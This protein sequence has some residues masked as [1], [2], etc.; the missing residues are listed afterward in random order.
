MAKEGLDVLVIERGEYPGSKNVSGALLHSHILLSIFPNFWDEA[1]VERFVTHRKLTFLTP[2]TSL[3]VDFR[4]DYFAK[5]P[6]NGFTVLR[7]K[8][9][10]WLAKKAEDAGALI[11]T[12]TL[13]EDLIW[14]GD[15][16]IGVKTR[17]QD[18]EVHAHV[19]IIAEGANSILTQ[20]AGLKRDMPPQEMAIGAKEVI[21]L[22]E[23]IINERFNLEG[24]EGAS[25]HYIGECTG[26]VPGGGFLYTNGNSISLG[27]VCRIWDLA[28]QRLKIFDLVE[29]FKSHPHISSLIK[30]GVLKE[31]SGHMIPEGGYK[32]MPKLSK[33]GLLV[34]GEAAS[35]NF[36]NGLILRGI[37]YA[38]ASGM[39]AARTVSMAKSS[40]DFSVKGLSRYSKEL[41][42][43]FVLKD[44]KRFKELPDILSNP[45]IFSTYPDLLCSLGREMFQVNDGERKRVLSLLND[46]RRREG[47]KVGIGK[48]IKDLLKMG[49]QI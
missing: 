36:N 15:R 46:V 13:V 11:M 31:Y 32:A 4:D 34:V 42:G 3:T 48:I 47:S 45:R 40:G 25:I 23:E 1:P 27:I 39:A 30:G 16:V 38:I 2:D 17:K 18:G 37:D 33:G 26:G 43:S 5:P 24:K 6:Y 41:E 7:S 8:F 28:K 12:G 22:S 10:P 14:E 19:V 44:M 29:R 20:K 9:D 49:Y 35:L 21:R